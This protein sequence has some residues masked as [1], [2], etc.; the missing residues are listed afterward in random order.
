MDLS[1]GDD[2]VATAESSI[3]HGGAELLFNFGA[4]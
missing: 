2:F 1:V 4:S 3:R